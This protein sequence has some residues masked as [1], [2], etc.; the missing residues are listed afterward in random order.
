MMIFRANTNFIFETA[1]KVSCLDKAGFLLA[2]VLPVTILFTAPAAADVF[3]YVK[4]GKIDVDV[5]SRASP[6]NLALN[7]GYELDSHLADLSLAAEINRS[8]DS[9][10]TGRREDLEFESNGVY[11]VYKSTRSLFTKLRVGI[12]D[13]KI[14]EGSSSQRSDGIAVGGGIGIVIGRTRL[15]IEYT[16]ISDDANH[17]T[18][19]LQF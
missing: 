14:I 18:I 9:G 19:G 7:I 12:V 6:T 8:I 11:L 13:N 3:T 16:V 10:K 2:A 15:Q 1:K 17:F 4:L 5:A